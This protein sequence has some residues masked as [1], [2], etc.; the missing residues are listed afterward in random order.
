MSRGHAAEDPVVGAQVPDDG[1]MDAVGPF[2]DQ[3]F[4]MLEG[5]VGIIG[6]VVIVPPLGSPGLPIQFLDG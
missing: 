6:D 3:L 2:T 5:R 4:F 1:W